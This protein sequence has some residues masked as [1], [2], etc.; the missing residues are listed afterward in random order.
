VLIYTGTKMFRA[1]DALQVAPERNPV[2]RLA[3][4]FLPIRKHYD[5]ANFF[6]RSPRGLLGTPLLLVLI[7]VEWTDLVFA[8]DSIPA[9]FAI[10]RDPFIIF[11]SN[12]FAVLGLR[13][14]FFLLAGMLD[15]FVY[16]KP[17]VA[18]VLVFIG[19][20][21]VVSY[22]VHVPIGLSLGVIVLALAGGVLLSLLHRAPSAAPAD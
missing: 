6:S 15:T 10:T 5:G 19:V 2:V 14:L 11:S 16:L 22:W 4:R 8:I 13:A 1:G 21:M 12:I 20:K 17:A 9:I 3:R 18:L 7:V